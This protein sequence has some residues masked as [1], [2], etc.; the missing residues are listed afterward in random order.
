MSRNRALIERVLNK[1]TSIKLRMIEKKKI[2]DP[3]RKNIIGQV[4]LT[5]E[6]GQQIDAFYENNYGEKIPHDWHRLYQSFTGNFQFDYFPDILFSAELEPRMNSWSYRYVLDDKMLLPLFTSNV[7]EV[8]VPEL[9]GGYAN[10]VYFDSYL[11]EQTKDSFAEQLCSMCGG[12]VIFKQTNDTDSGKGV[13]I[14]DLRISERNEVEK[15]IEAYRGQAFV[16]QKLISQHSSLADIYPDSVNTFRIVTYIW[17]GK[18]YHFPVALR[19]GRNGNRVDNAHAGGLFIGIT[20]EGQFMD[21]AYTEFKDIFYTHPDTGYKFKG[22]RIPYVPRLIAAAERM[23]MNALCLGIISWD[24][25][26]DSDG[27]VV[28]IEANTSG[29]TIWF[30]QMANGKAAFGDNTAEILI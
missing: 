12:E 6:Q 20:D 26:M 30:P 4:A 3:R 2:R 17:K 11:K 19:L 22:A 16:V 21:A 23:H 27:E 8:R 13:Q 9:I 7:P 14:C 15:I 5:P 18:I 1:Y 28:L 24:L 25:T 29:Q 10:G